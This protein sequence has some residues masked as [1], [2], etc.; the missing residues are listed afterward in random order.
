M[1][2]LITGLDAA[3]VRANLE[4][5]RATIA[6]AGRDPAGYEILCAVKYVPS[7]ELGVTP[8][9]ETVSRAMNRIP[10]LGLHE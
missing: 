3:R 1:A 9:S 8:P 5:V 2:E 4:R 10:L 6:D 7:D